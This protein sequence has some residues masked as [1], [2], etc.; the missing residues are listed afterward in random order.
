MR[1]KGGIRKNAGRPK[2]S[3]NKLTAVA[4]AN[5]VELAKAHTEEMLLILVRLARNSESDGVRA[6]A[7]VAVL[8]RG[9]GKPAQTH[10]IAGKDGQPIILEIVRFSDAK[11]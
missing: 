11:T 10:E 4:N 8:D 7:G 9:N 1:P 5:L 3:R 6:E 2:G